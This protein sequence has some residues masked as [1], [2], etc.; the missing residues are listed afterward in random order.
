MIVVA[1]TTQVARIPHR[2]SECG[3]LIKPAETY[4]GQRNIF[5]REPYVSK[6]HPEF[7]DAILRRDL[8]VR[9]W[10]KSDIQLPL[11]LGPR[12]TA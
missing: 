3:G 2:C 9:C 5:E 4:H 7:S 11:A 6:A 8:N 1:N 10:H 12:S